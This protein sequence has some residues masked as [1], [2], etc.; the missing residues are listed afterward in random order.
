MPLLKRYEFD[1]LQIAIWSIEEEVEELTKLVRPNFHTEINHRARNVQWL[2]CR[3]ALADIMPDNN[4][5][6]YKDE[7]G[8]PHVSSEEHIS[9]SHTFKYAAATVSNQLVGIDIEELT[10]RIERIATRF[11]HIEEKAFLENGSSL[12]HLY[13]IWCAKEAIFK[14]YGKKAVR[15]SK[16]IQVMPFEVEESGSLQIQFARLRSTLFTARYLI[17]DNHV[18]VWVEDSVS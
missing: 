7:Y 1:Q 18:L 8:K 9:L 12:E 2:A 15:F 13:L 5:E 17:F 4:F 14:L 10:P 16:D 6:L 11:L 3:A